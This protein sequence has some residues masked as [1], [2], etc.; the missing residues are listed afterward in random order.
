MLKTI[1]LSLSLA[2]AAGPAFGQVAAAAKP[3]AAKKA[4]A[5]QAAGDPAG[6]TLAAVPTP[7]AAPAEA[8][9][10]PASGQA[11]VVVSPP[12]APSEERQELDKLSAENSLVAQEVAKK[13]RAVIAEKE[14]L[15][16]RSELQVEKNKAALADLDAAFQR[17][18]L[19]NRLQE[20]QNKKLIEALTSQQKK[21]SAENA[22][23][24]EKHKQELSDLRQAKEKLQAA[25]DRL[26]EELRA[27]EMKNQAEKQSL[28]LEGAR[29]GIESMRMKAEREKLEDKL[30]KL[31]TDIES[32]AKRDEWKNEA[33]KEPVV[34][35]DPFKNGLLTIS[36]RRITLNGVILRGVADYVSERLD[37]FNN[38]SDD[39]VFVVIDRCPGGSVMEGYRIV[40]AIQ[41]SKAPVHVVVTSFAAS[42]C[43][44]I[45]TLAPHS[46]V[47]PNAIV[48]HHQMSTVLWG[49][50]TQTKEQLAIAGEWWRRLADPVAKKM[51]T[52][53]D[54]LVKKMYAKNSDGDW[55]E[56]GDRA[57][58]LRWA[59]RV[60]DE[61]RETGV[62]KRPDDEKSP[63]PGLR[64]FALAEKTDEKGERYVRLPRLE[65]FDLY[66][67]YNPDRYYR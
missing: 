42:M 64:P 47:Y 41:A 12:R 35:K 11:S 18:S 60:V 28:D 27:E 40:K 8:S 66:W 4:D 26:R 63:N 34:L 54:G 17:L 20:E 51:G 15:R 9:G 55:E 65:P 58:A 49:N 53:L 32:R 39:P 57:V 43:A 10:T 24:E 13:L 46:Y 52:D 25:N 44:V 22:L 16:I 6:A 2:L 67:I 48:L 30:A 50:M 19:E 3:R 36:D 31:K 56:F 59:D 29:L 45:T 23:D 5:A 14:E 37:F 62:K 61:I 38:V 1:S 33:N 7:A 21:V